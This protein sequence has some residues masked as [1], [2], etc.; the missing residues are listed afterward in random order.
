M[1]IYFL[2]SLEKM[3]FKEKIDYEIEW[4]GIDQSTVLIL[5]CSFNRT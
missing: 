3:R 5:P 4:T 2:L 1:N